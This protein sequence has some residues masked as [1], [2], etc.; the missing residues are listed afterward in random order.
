[1]VQERPESLYSRLGG[2]DVI[3]TYVDNVLGLV[4][5]D[6]RLAPYFRGMSADTARRTRQLIL[7]WVVATSGGP[8]IF[9]GR[10]LRVSHEGMG[11][12]ESE[13]TL[14]LAHAATAL[15]SVGVAHGPKKELLAL[16]A[17]PSVQGEIVEQK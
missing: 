14:L 16:L 2:Y 6:S 4:V 5:S 12:T 15:D 7:D 11:I 1:M 17:S 13:Y 9:T 3:A 8:A 10:P